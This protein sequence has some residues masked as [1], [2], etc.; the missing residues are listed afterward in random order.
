MTRHHEQQQH[1][2]QHIF[3]QSRS[4]GFALCGRFGYTACTLLWRGFIG[5][6][7]VFG[8]EFGDLFNDDLVGYYSRGVLSV[9]DGLDVGAPL[10]FQMLFQMLDALLDG[11]SREVG[12]RN[13]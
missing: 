12:R 3:D 2:I 9:L 6:C 10:L 1:H 13:K 4:V 5:I 8:C 11:K 7:V